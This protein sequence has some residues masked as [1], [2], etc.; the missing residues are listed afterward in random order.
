[1]SVGGHGRCSVSEPLVWR[2]EGSVHLGQ[3]AGQY[4]GLD[5]TTKEL[6]TPELGSSVSGCQECDS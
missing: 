2:V 4:K 1:M 5:L 6:V 3:E